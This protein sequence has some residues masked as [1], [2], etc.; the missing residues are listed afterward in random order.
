[1]RI[2]ETLGRISD[3]QNP[4]K[5]LQT[6]FKIQAQALAQISRSSAK[7][8]NHWPKDSD[9]RPNIRDSDIKHDVVI[10]HSNFILVFLIQ[11]LHLYLSSLEIV[12][13]ESR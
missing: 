3:L 11:I 5:D 2:N 1:M 7:S 6:I 9:L 13:H 4:G 10:S 12:Y 8:L